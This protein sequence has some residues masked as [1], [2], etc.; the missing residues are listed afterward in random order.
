MSLASR[1][2]IGRKAEAVNRGWDL[3]EFC[4]EKVTCLFF[5]FTLSAPQCCPAPS[6]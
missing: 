2:N 3:K 5:F 1:K 6:T 4:W